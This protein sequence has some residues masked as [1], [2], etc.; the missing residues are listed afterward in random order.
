MPGY[1]DGTITET[2]EILKESVSA[3]SAR[4]HEVAAMTNS[5]LATYSALDRRVMVTL[6]REPTSV[7]TMSDR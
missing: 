3:N 4:G 5:Q 7:C 2:N 1:E 6:A